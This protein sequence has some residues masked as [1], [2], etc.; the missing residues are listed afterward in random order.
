MNQL[1]KAVGT[2]RKNIDIEYAFDYFKVGKMHSTPLDIF[3]LIL[4]T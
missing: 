1:Q 4:H 2:F 3:H